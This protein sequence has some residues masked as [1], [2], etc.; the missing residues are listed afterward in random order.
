MVTDF[1]LAAGA[2]LCTTNDCLIQALI[3]KT[4]EFTSYNIAPSESYACWIFQPL[5]STPCSTGKPTLISATCPKPYKAIQGRI[6][7]DP[8]PNPGFWLGRASTGL[9]W[10]LMSTLNLLICPDILMAHRQSCSDLHFIPVENLPIIFCSG[11][12]SHHR[13]YPGGTSK[14][15]CLNYA[16]LNWSC[17]SFHGY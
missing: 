2:D 12:T 10:P 15:K 16:G 5:G 6:S 8:Y 9:L 1:F 3:S 4:R 14:L 17:L 11:L 7:F 13:A